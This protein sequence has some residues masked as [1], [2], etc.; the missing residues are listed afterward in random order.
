MAV[1]N[2]GEDRRGALGQPVHPAVEQR[3]EQ[4]VLARE[5]P[6]DPR[7]DDARL[8]PDVGQPDGVEPAARRELGRRGED[9]LPALGIAATTGVGRDHLVIM[10]AGRYGRHK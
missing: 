8:R 4:R 2:R 3:D 5:V 6:V 9:A 10:A 7:A 1:G